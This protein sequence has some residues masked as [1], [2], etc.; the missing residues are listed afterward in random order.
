MIDRDESRLIVEELRNR[1][2]RDAAAHP[3]RARPRRRG[4][5]APAEK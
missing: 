2:R 3:P 4:T 5:T 1:A